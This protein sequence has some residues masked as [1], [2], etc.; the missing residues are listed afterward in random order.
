LEKTDV[1]IV[2]NGLVLFEGPSALDG[3]P[4]TVIITGVRGSSNRKTGNMLQ[5]WILRSDVD[6]IAAVST[7]RDSSVC[8]QC[9]L[10]GQVLDGHNRGRACYVAAPRGP[11]AIYQSYKHDR[12][13]KYDPALHDRLLKT[14][15]LRIGAYGDPCAAPFAVSSRL[16]R[17]V[18][19]NVG[20]THMW[21]NR[22][23]WR[24]RSLCMASC[25]TLADARQ[26][27][28]RGW[29]TFRTLRDVNDI[30][31]EDEILCPA[32]EEAGHKTQCEQCLLC[33]GLHGSRSNAK[34]PR[35]NVA[36]VVHGPAGTVASYRRL[37]SGGPNDGAVIQSALLSTTSA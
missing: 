20:Y 33:N 13:A 3:E 12:Y 27:Q 21:R 19:G 26:A 6:P 11:Q 32:S 16:A 24:F 14:R 28:S 8:G 35:K 1:S 22:R 7:G 10:R 9:P 37:I 31:R 29:R 17:V 34:R 2:P 30:C 36:I 18:N 4:I 25:E 23:F 15:K 5:S